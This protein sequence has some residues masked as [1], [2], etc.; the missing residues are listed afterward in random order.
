MLI[1][2]RYQNLPDLG[3]SFGGFGDFV[4]NRLGPHKRFIV[5]TQVDGRFLSDLLSSKGIRGR[6]T[7]DG[8]RLRVIL[9]PPL[10]GNGWNQRE[11]KL[12]S[13][14]KRIYGIG[15][16]AVRPKILIF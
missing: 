13:G 2:D 9:H 5:D 3:K 6:Y 4:G 14:R 15:E 8:R 1:F 12:A 7:K 16:R 10:Y 11:R